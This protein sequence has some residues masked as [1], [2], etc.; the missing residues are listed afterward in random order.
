MVETIG[1][2]INTLDRVCDILNLFTE[3]DHVLT[4]SN[5]SRR[6][7]LPKSTA[8]R[9]LAAMLLRGLLIRDPYDRG[10]QLG[11]QLLQWGTLARSSLDIRNIALPV[12]KALV[13]T[14]NETVVLSMRYGNSAI[15]V[16][17][18]ESEQPVRIALRTGKPL[19]LHAGASSK[20]LWAFLP[21][22]EMEAMF[23]VIHLAPLFANSIIESEKMRTELKKIREL[24]YAVSYEET[25]PGAMGIAAPVYDHLNC[26][27]AGLGMVA[28]AARVTTD[29]VEVYAQKVREASVELSRRLGAPNRNQK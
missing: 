7:Q 10:Y 24:G 2:G 8:H 13:N 27:V 18:V 21:Q 22:E 14:I 17:V 3:E 1:C 11:F 12:M 26:L 16:E 23:G 4:L 20:I 28:P 25:D 5:I 9:M 6:L 19:S 15:W 29:R